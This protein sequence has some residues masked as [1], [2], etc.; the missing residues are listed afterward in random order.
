M[1]FNKSKTSTRAIFALLLIAIGL[2]SSTN[3]ASAQQISAA[4]ILPGP[5]PTPSQYNRIISLTQSLSQSIYDLG[6]QDKLLGCTSYCSIALADNKEIVASSIKPNLE[7]I[8]SLNPDLVLAMGLTPAKDI[9]TLRKLGIRVE[10]FATPKTFEEICGQ[11]NTIGLLLGHSEQAQKIVD[12]A[13]LK[14]QAILSQQTRTANKPQQTKIFMQIGADPIFSVLPH[15]FM[16]DYIKYCGGVNIAADLK[17]GIVGREFVA[18]R[19]PDYIFIAT[20]G[21]VGEQEKEKW[22]QFRQLQA[23]RQKQIFTIDSNIACLPTPN[24]F[25]E[26]LELMI[27]QMNK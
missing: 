15:T 12:Q 19:N 27:K 17:T 5:T 7:K 2:L 6:A 22:S 3:L 26:T 4:E 21:M 9:A 18:A 20:M 24:T 1:N 11:F 16:D 14:V 8:A 25:V 23:T 13:K 10:V